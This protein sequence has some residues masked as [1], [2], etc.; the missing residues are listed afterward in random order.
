MFAFAANRVSPR[1]LMLSRNYF[2]SGT[3]NL[4]RSAA[5][6]P[7]GKSAVTNPP[8]IEQLISAQVKKEGF[9]WVENPQALELFRESESN[10][11]IVFIDARDDESYRAAHIPRAREFDPYHPE[12]YFPG[13]LPACQT[14]EKIV[15][16]CNGGD[17]D[18]S[19]TAALLLKE[20]GISAQKL[21]IYGGGITE[22]TNRNLPVQS[23]PF[24][25]G[26]TNSPTQ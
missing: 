10:H 8:S 14:A 22:W 9:Q 16:Y 25:G 19:Q 3:N 24:A 4:I 11:G 12:E 17:C 2:P 1:G 21:L 7:S 18:D 15:V 6:V 13:A 23:G 26:K 5:V 20:V